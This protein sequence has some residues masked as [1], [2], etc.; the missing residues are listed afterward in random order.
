MEKLNQYMMERALP[1]S[2]QVTLRKYYRYFWSRR[3]VFEHE[4][5]ILSDLRSVR[6]SSMRVGQAGW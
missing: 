3:T 6:K 5:E 4:E 2:L 1:R